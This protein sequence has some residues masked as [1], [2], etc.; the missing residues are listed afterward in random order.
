MKPTVKVPPQLSAKLIDLKNYGLSPEQCV[1][2]LKRDY[3]ALA[4]QIVLIP[5]DAVRMDDVSDQGATGLDYDMIRRATAHGHIDGHELIEA[6]RRALELESQAVEF[7]QEFKR[8]TTADLEQLKNVTGAL[9]ETQ[10]NTFQQQHEVNLGER[11]QLDPLT[12]ARLLYERLQ[13]SGE[14][15][16]DLSAALP[17]D[18]RVLL[19]AKPESKRAELPAPAD[20]GKTIDVAQVAPKRRGLFGLG[21]E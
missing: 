11:A 2:V 7:E 8:Q 14:I 16:G 4:E 17:A 9:I 10:F 21:G 3:P 19:E 20:S 12:G 15:V 18:F 13:A 5:G 6:K 1:S